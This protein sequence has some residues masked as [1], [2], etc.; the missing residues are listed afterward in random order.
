MFQKIL[1]ANRGEIAVRVIRTCKDMGIGT[2]AVYSEADRR[3]LHRLEADQAVCI[4]ASDPAQSY[5]NMDRIIE[6]ARSTGSQAIHPGYGFLSENPEFADCCHRAG[7]VFIGPPARV[8]RDMGDKLTARRIMIRAGVP[9]VPGLSGT[10]HT[11][12]DMMKTA[13][14]VGYPV[15]IK[16]SAGGGGKGIRRVDSPEEMES[17]FASASREALKAFGDGRVY[18]EKCFTRARHIE[19]QILA[20]Q[21]GRTIHILERECSV[22]RRHQKIIEETPSLA[23]SPGLRAEMGEA[24]CAAAKAAGYV[25]AGTVDFLL[26]DQGRF[27]FMEM[28]TRLQV[29]HPITEL[30]TGIDLVRQQI[31]LAAGLPLALSQDDISAR[32][33]AIECRIYAED[34]ENG[35]F[36]CPGRITCY[37]EPTGPGIRNDSGIHANAAVP[38]EYD[39]ILSKLSVHAETRDQAIARMIQALKS[40][41]VLGVRTPVDFMADVLDSADFRAGIVF[42][43]F[44]DTHFSNWRPRREKADLACLAFI[45]DELCRVSAPEDR[46]GDTR[47]PGPFQT[48][49][50]WTL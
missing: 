50:R 49:G 26:D 33:H 14:Q 46:P 1:I 16:A 15:L 24:A 43:D 11:L 20:D 4:G 23:L 2:V 34:P 8:I 19:F 21:A 44:I 36:P 27:Y 47:V 42:T 40:Y 5:L 39:P 37:Q 38:V 30:V 45:A 32:G 48:L 25:N 31:L 29:E 28:N 9:V 10:E 18:L 41:I 3:A 22:Q 7:I 35:F 13:R 12:E 17:A 6:A